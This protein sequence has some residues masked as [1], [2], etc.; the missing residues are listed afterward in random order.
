MG[1]VMIVVGFG[2]MLAVKSNTILG[3]GG[4]VVGL[5]GLAIMWHFQITKRRTLGAGSVGDDEQDRAAAREN[6]S[7][8]LRVV[9]TWV[10]RGLVVAAL[11]GTVFMISGDGVRLSVAPLAILAGC[12]LLFIVLAIRFRREK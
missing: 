3:A 5:V 9:L 7:S 2:T 11:V 8:V 4:F 6:S 1:I 10:S 12:L